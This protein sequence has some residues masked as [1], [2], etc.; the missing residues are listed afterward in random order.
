MANFN[1]IVVT[2]KGRELLAKIEANSDK[3]VF[4]KIQTSDIKYNKEQLKKLT[5]LISIKQERS[6]QK[7]EYKAP[8][9]VRVVAEIDNLGLVEGYNV[10]SYGILAK[11]NNLPEVLF[12]AA[13]NVGDKADWMS[14]NGSLNQMRIRLSSIL[15]IGSA[16]LEAITV[17][18]D[19]AVSEET[20]YSHTEEGGE[21][22]V[23]NS[24]SEAEISTIISRDAYGSAKIK[25][26]VTPTDDTIVNKSALDSAIKETVSTAGVPQEQIINSF[27]LYK[28]Y[29]KGDIIAINENGTT[30]DWNIGNPNPTETPTQPDTPSGEDKKEEAG[31]TESGG[32]VTPTERVQVV[33]AGETI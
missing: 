5:A 6:V 26:P 2:D 10:E 11:G 27:K 16:E 7:I 9:M 8:D 20:F 13:S 14:P 30:E 32:T 15:I 28:E 4:T 3:L 22:G 33:T 18:T 23:H 17:I 29:K 19:G 24:T 21:S 12:A 25:Y 31:G 1:N